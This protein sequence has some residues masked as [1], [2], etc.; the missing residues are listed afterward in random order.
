V[1][2]IRGVENLADE[3]AKVFQLDLKSPSAFALAQH[4]KLQPQDVVYVGP[5]DVTRWN[6]FI[7]QVFPS[8]N[9]LRTGVG[10]KDDLGTSN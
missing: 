5:A 3:P 1:Y 6:R 7:S 8:A 10:I 9:L 4:I 2:V